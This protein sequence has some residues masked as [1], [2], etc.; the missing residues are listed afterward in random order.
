[1]LVVQVIQ[2]LVVFK[3][4]SFCLSTKSTGTEITFLVKFNFLFSYDIVDYLQVNALQDRKEGFYNYYF[5]YLHGR[6]VQYELKSSKGEKPFAVAVDE[7]FTV[8]TSEELDT[9]QVSVCYSDITCFVS[10]K[11][12]Q[13]VLYHWFFVVK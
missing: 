12:I 8:P 10:G 3:S 13:N 1:M 9:A 2:G 5:S 7:E 6:L 4:S 11:L